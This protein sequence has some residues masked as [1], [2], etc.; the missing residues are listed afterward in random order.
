VRFPKQG[1]Q[2]NNIRVQGPKTLVNKIVAAIQAQVEQKA[3]QVS[4]TMEVPTEKHRVLIGRGGEARRNLETKFN[5]SID[6]PRQGATG[7][8]ASQIKLTGQP[9]DIEQAKTHIAGLIKEQEGETVNVPRKFHND[10]SDNGQ[11]FRRLRNDHRVTVDHAGQQPPARL[12][13]RNPRARANGGTILPLITDDPSAAADAHSWELVDNSSVYEGTDGDETIP[14]ILRGSPEGV[15][16]SKALL[17]QALANAQKPSWSG[18]LILPDPKTYRHI[19]GPGGSTIN[20]IRKKTGT[21][22]QVPRGQSE[23]EAVEIV[24]TKEGVEEAKL[25]ILDVIK[26]AGNGPRR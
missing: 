5:I 9:A 26:T 1:D 22:I 14:W 15:A 13:A 10:V 12:A 7:P 6:I 24:G 16:K 20:N 18:Y 2:D 17:E 11:F 21:K 23:G 25:L 3:G 8:A 4:G 19:I